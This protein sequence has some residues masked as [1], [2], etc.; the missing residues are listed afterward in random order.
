MPTGSYSIRVLQLSGY[1]FTPTDQT[2]TGTLSCG[3]TM[4]TTFP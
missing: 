3:Q 2:Y 1:V 4:T